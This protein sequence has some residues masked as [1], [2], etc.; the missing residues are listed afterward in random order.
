MRRGR[1]VGRPG[2]V[3]LLEVAFDTRERLRL[4][5][6][7]AAGEAAHLALRSL[8]HLEAPARLRALL[9][10]FGKLV[11]EAHRVRDLVEFVGVHVLGRDLLAQGLQFV[12][13]EVP[14]RQLVLHLER[15]GGRDA[16]SLERGFRIATAHYFGGAAAEPAAAALAGGAL[17]GGA[18]AVGVFVLLRA[19]L[20]NTDR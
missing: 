17:E 1:N 10:F 7:A 13:I 9:K 3:E 5:M 4:A 18:A 8:S 2:A 20:M 14:R 11:A 6:E 16:E 12:R 19:C 15:F